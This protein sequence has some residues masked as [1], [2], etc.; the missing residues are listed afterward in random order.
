MG[1]IKNM[2]LVEVLFCFFLSFVAAANINY[3]TD[4]GASAICDVYQ[5]VEDRFCS[6]ITEGMCYF[7]ARFKS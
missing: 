1:L 4:S 6:D 2:I 5:G 3:V 7:S